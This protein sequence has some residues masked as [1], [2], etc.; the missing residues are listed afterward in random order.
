MSTPHAA[1]GRPPSSNC[2]HTAVFPR[3]GAESKIRT[4]SSMGRAWGVHKPEKCGVQLTVGAHSILLPSPS[5]GRRW[6]QARDSPGK[7]CD[8]IREEER[9]LC[10][11]RMSCYALY[12]I[13]RSEERYQMG[14]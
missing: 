6:W 13:P 10:A 2:V 11:M 7:P 14:F 8:A 1:W 4:L 9:G 12:D 3:G 5:P